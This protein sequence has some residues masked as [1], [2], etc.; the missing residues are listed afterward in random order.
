MVFD[1]GNTVQDRRKAPR[2]RAL[3]AGKIVLNSRRSV[4]DCVIRNL[5]GTGASLEVASVLGIP[6]TFDLQIGGEATIR[7][8]VAVWRGQNRIGVEFQSS[9]C[10]SPKRTASN[11]LDSAG[12]QYHD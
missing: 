4:I 5:C 7:S 12:S 10:A 9:R 8:C 1:E 11:R 3:R 2:P 6:A